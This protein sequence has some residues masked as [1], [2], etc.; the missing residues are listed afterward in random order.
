MALEAIRAVD[1][2]IVSRLE[3]HLSVFSAIGAHGGEHLAWATVV[4]AAEAASSAIRSATTISV[5]GGSAGGATARV[6]LKT[7]AGEELLLPRGKHKGLAA[8]PT[9]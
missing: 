4:A 2:A 3:R 9:G 8:I 5:A 6:I 7:S 1:R